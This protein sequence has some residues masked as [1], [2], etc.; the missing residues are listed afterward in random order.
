MARCTL[1]D[2]NR[3]MHWWG[4]ALQFA[5]E[6]SNYIMTNAVDGIPPEA[7]WKD[8]PID[9]SHFRVPL[10]DCYFYVEHINRDNSSLSLVIREPGVFVGCSKDS[11]SFVS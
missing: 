11:P 1:S 6:I 10:C 8:Q 7:A 4:V 9:F 3:E 2:Q 5:T